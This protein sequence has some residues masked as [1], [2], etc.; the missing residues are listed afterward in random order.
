[1]NSFFVKGNPSTPISTSTGQ[2]SPTSQNTQQPKLP[3]NEW[4][5]EEVIQYI[6]DT[7]PGLAIHA[8]LFRKHVRFFLNFL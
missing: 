2:Q 1:M 6:A 8:D 5:I 3:P 7:D 4:N